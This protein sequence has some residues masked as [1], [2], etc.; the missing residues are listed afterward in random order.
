MASERD[1]DVIRRARASLDNKEL[2]DRDAPSASEGRRAASAPGAPN[3][4]DEK[5][6]M[7]RG[8]VIRQGGGTPGAPSA[9]GRAPTTRG[10]GRST[11]AG[12]GSGNLKVA[13]ERLTDL[14]TDGLITKAEYEKK[15][16]Q[17]L[18]RL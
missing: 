12:S 8:K 9:K 5:V 16:S 7:Y 2:V 6:L 11:A 14:Y 17:I 18:D 4:K 15:R 1:L 13:L 3:H 10:A